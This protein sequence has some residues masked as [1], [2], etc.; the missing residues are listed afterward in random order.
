MRLWGVGAARY[1]EYRVCVW[2]VWPSALSFSFPVTKRHQMTPP[3]NCIVRVRGS[4]RCRHRTQLHLLRNSDDSDASRRWPAMLRVAC[5]ARAWRVR[6]VARPS[7]RAAAA[8]SRDARARAEMYASSLPAARPRRRAWQ[9][10]CVSGRSC[11]G[12]RQVASLGAEA[13][14]LTGKLRAVAEQ[15]PPRPSCEAPCSKLPYP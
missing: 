5:L 10:W 3:H 2:C 14:E 8:W 6:P 11:T 4:E 1:I 7:D 15:C 9:A 13:P 12:A